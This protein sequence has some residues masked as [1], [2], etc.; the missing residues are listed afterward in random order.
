[1]RYAGYRLSII[2]LITSLIPAHLA[3]IGV[4]QDIAV[5]SEST[6]TVTAT[7]TEAVLAILPAE[8]VPLETAAADLTVEAPVATSLPDIATLTATGT[9]E[10]PVSATP[11]EMTDELTSLP[12]ETATA[13][14]EFTPEVTAEI[15]PDEPA[16]IATPEATATDMSASPILLPSG[17]PLDRVQLVGLAHYQ[18]R[19]PD[20]AGIVAMVHDSQGNLVSQTMTDA[21]GVFTLEIPAQEPY[22]LSLAAP[23]HLQ[24]ELVLPANSLPSELWLAGGDLNQDGCINQQDID[25]VTAEFLLF[26]PAADINRDGVVSSIDIAVLTGNYQAECVAGTNNPPSM[27]SSPVPTLSP[28]DDLTL[29]ATEPVISPPE[30]T[31]EAGSMQG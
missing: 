7:A 11:P 19:L 20:D 31:L 6:G 1:M 23:Q 25:L 15:T 26:A 18:N 29:E 8:I 13:I 3:L 9:L 12:S 4:A 5:T 2:F 27:Q 17:T 28:A 22:R 14:A 24:I 21:A 16:A 10:M 30:A